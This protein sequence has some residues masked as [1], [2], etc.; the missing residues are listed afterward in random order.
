VKLGEVVITNQENIDG[1]YPYEEILY[2]DTGSIIKG[3]IEQLQ[4]LKI[5]DS[6]SRAKRL[7]KDG[8]IIYSSVRPIQRH[9]GFIKNPPENLVVST[10]FIVLTVKTEKSDPRFI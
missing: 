5:V 4:K 6:P 1:S 7:V 10:G 8:D 2:L 9:Y 3:K